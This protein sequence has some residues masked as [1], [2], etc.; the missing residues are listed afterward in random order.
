LP[1]TVL[2]AAGLAAV[3]ELGAPG[4]LDFDDMG[5]DEVEEPVVSSSRR[6]WGE[7]REKEE[8]GVRSRSTREKGEKE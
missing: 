3:V 2:V 7:K 4:H 6:S 1:A 8:T 5:F